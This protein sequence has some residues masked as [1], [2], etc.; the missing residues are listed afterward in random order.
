MK[1]CGIIFF[2]TCIVS[3]QTY[4]QEPDTSA[5]KLNN[6]LPN[7]DSS[8]VAEE[9]QASDVFF[10]ILKIKRK[11][12]ILEEDVKIGKLL[13]AILPGIGYNLQSSFTGIITA[14][15]SFYL[16]E[17]KTTN[18]SVFNSDAEYS[19]SH[20]QVLIPFVFNVWLK[21]NK[22]NY[23]GDIRYLIFPSSTYGL[24]AFSDY[25]KF[26]RINYNYLK[27]YLV[28]FKPLH[29]DFYL[30]IGYNLDYHLN[31]STSDSNTNF[32]AYNGNV[33]KTISSGVY[34][35]LKYDSRRNINNPQGGAY[36]NV[37]FRPNSAL[38]GSDNDW[39]SLL[40]E[41][42]KYFKFK[43]VRSNIL[44]FWS[45]NW[46]TFGKTPY[47]DLPSTG[48]DTYANVGRGYIQGRF[49]GTKLIY[50]ESEYRFG[51]TRN[52]LFG[53]VLFANAQAVTEWPGN[54]FER[55]IPAGGTGLRIKI[56]KRSNVNFAI[57]YAVGINGSGGF[58]FNIS[59]IF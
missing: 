54:K 38:T 3:L 57:D 13:L 34:I 47:L 20:Q 5:L 40:I 16:G 31:I 43:T 51:I 37:A 56:N 53:M 50:L 29:K 28:G 24:G 59:E 46:L 2:L 25:N 42:R 52:G 39:Q 45:Y 44:A 58:F 22:F 15:V 49:R 17:K 18:I 4:A 7:N 6:T 27:V 55:I 14:N 10:Q 41:A 23:T 33:T 12:K 8:G 9:K 26:D 21:N 19:P 11:K 36:C 35:S 48:W 1:F 30:G 32:R